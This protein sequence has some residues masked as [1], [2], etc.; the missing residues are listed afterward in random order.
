MIPI[1][2]YLDHDAKYPLCTVLT[3]F[4]VCLRECNRDNLEFASG[5]EVSRSLFKTFDD[6]K[7]KV[8]SQK[9]FTLGKDLA[10]LGLSNNVR[11]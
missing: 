9:P 4:T 10:L 3:T 11:H 1:K 6:L 7:S 2:S 8:Q 5:S